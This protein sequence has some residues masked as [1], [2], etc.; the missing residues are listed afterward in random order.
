[1]TV[2]LSLLFALLLSALGGAL[3]LATIAERRMAASYDRSVEALYAADG[4]VERAI[5][6]LALRAD[7][8]AALD[9][10]LRSSFVD[11]PPGG[12]RLL[13]DGSAL[14]LTRITNANTPRLELFAYGSM[15]AL[16]PTPVTPEP[17]YVVVWVG[18]DPA[19]SDGRPLVDTNGVVTLLAHAYGG[20]AT[21][22]MLEVTVG[23]T[24]TGVRIIAWREIRQ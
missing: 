18:D 5:D 17:P 9:G 7:W 1:M 24:P 8:S 11:G 22:R 23:R 14:D 16:L 13:P 12:A 21:R 6:D 10:S 3:A 19:D 2:T 4:A 15:A 20:A